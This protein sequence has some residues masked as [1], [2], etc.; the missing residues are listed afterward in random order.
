ML[1][2]FLALE[3]NLEITSRILKEAGIEIPNINQTSLAKEH[4]K[5]TCIPISEVLQMLHILVSEKEFLTA[6]LLRISN[7]LKH[8]S[9]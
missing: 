2:S 7:H 9:Q 8:L 3:I 1:T 6:S 4:S 5:K